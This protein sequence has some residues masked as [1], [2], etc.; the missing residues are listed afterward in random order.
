MA[1]EYCLSTLAQDDMAEEC[2]LS[3]LAL[4]QDDR[5]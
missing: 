1:E 2:G 5:R 4:A 3:T